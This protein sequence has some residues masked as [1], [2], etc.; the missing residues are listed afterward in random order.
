[1]KLQCD[2]TL[3]A[4]PHLVVRS[5][6]DDQLLISIPFSSL[7]KIRSIKVSAPSGRCANLAVS[8]WPA[9]TPTRCAGDTAP[10]RV[11]V[12]INQPGLGFDDV[13]DISATQE[14]ELSADMLKP[15]AP[16]LQVSDNFDTMQP[17]VTWFGHLS[18]VACCH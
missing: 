17:D 5:D 15:E 9:T 2:L 3:N 13:Q 12:F 7:C 10:T 14:W 11:K 8:R 6:A 16:A 4:D 18:H 1:M